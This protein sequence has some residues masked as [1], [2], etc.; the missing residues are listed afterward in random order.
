MARRDSI[1]DHRSDLIEFTTIAEGFGRAGLPHDG[2]RDGIGRTLA[3][4]LRP[5]HQIQFGLARA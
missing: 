3:Y 5:A 4:I 1:H 2:G